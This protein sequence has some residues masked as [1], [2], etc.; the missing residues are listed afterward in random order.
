MNDAAEVFLRAF[1]ADR[2]AGRLYWRSPP[3]NHPNLLGKEA[4]FLNVGKGKN[5]SYWQVRLGGKTYKRS[6]VMFL[7]LHGRWPSQCIDHINGDSLDDRPENLRECSQAENS[8]NISK[9]SRKASGLPRGV[10]QW[11]GRYAARVTLNQRTLFL[12][13]FDISEQAEAACRAKRE[14][15]F[16]VFA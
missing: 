5:K 8:R 1:C 2:V 15:V 12:G 14:E 6:R 16:G 13:Y 3:K 7:V 10:T 4:G 11:K 9:R